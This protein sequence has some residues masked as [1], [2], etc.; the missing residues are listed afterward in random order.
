MENIRISE[1]DTVEV[2]KL[3]DE[4]LNLDGKGKLNFRAEIREDL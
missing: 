2:S 4:L 1:I 3:L